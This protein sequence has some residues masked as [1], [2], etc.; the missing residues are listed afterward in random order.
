MDYLSEAICC[1]VNHSWSETKM[2][3]S[4]YSA[5]AVSKAVSGGSFWPVLFIAFFSIVS[6]VVCAWESSRLCNRI[7]FATHYL[8]TVVYQIDT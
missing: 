6:R 1:V 4:G 2:G 7:C 5:A 8:W 3:M